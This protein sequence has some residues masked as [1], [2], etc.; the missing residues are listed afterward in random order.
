MKLSLKDLA[1]IKPTEIINKKLLK[2]KKITGVSTDSRS[3]KPGNIF[4]ALRGERFDG[5][6][7]V[8]AVV[9]SGAVAV[10]V[11][12]KWAKDNHGVA[13][14]LG[15]ATM[16]VPDTTRTLGR[17]AKIYRK[18]FSIPI[19]AIGGSNGKTTTKEMVSAVL[20][21]TYEVL[22]TEGNLNNHI[23]VPQ[24]L[25]RLTSK[26]D[27]AVIELGTNHF[28]ELE[29]LCDMLEPTHALIT[30]IGREHLEFFGDEEGVAKEETVLFKS[31][32]AKGF[33]FVNAD[34]SRLLKAGRKVRK[35]MKFGTVRMADVQA[36]HVRL[37][38]FGQPAFDLAVKKKS[39]PVQLTASGMHNVSNAL[40]AAAVGLKFKVPQKKI[41][42]AV[43]KYSGANKRMEVITR[44]NITILNDTYNA[45]PDSVLAALKTLQSLKTGGKKIVVLADMLELGDKAEHEHAKIGLAVS[46]MEFEY[47]LTFGPLSRFTYEASKLAFA[48]HFETKE[49]L[50]ASLKSQIAPGDAVLIKGSRGMKMEEVTAQI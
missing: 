46:D 32:A 31:V 9:K 12:E 35:S 38:E 18:K 25:F 39:S 27:V 50:I 28:G 13:E 48:E 19:V 6:Q 49:A 11:D 37:N 20:R 8:E 1:K 2:N 44:N 7:F 43:E 14:R 23:G 15:S 34:D 4:I 29:Y 17:L 47:L 24:N 33:A 40:A 30:N 3:I 16:I 26:H 22:S 36:Q 45:N 10:I 5:H 21:T 42:S 41:I